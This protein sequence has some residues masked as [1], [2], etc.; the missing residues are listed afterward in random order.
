MKT[1]SLMNFYN[2]ESTINSNST[3]RVRQYKYSKTYSIEWRNNEN[4]KLHREDGPAVM[5]ASGGQE[6]WVNGKFHREDG[7]AV[8]HADG[9][10]SWWINGEL[11]REDGPAVEHVNGRKDWYQN[12]KRHCLDG[13]AVEHANGKKEWYVNNQKLT[14]QE[15]NLLRG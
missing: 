6:W 12:G 8:E 10:K 13:P 9:D 3:P 11:H 1:K 4:G 7:P 5:R 15:F 2:L 14:E